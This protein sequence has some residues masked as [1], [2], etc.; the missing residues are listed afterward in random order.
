MNCGY[1]IPDGYF[2][3]M[4]NVN[5]ENR[6]RLSVPHGETLFYAMENSSESQR[7]LCGS[8]RGFKMTMYDHTHQEALYLM[9]SATFGCCSFWCKM[10]VSI[11]LLS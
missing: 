1:V 5:S 2:V 3:V 6:Y 10:Q 7:M 8:N 4:A 11:L 9:R